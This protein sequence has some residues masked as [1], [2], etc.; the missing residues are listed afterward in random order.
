MVDGQDTE[1]RPIEHRRDPFYNKNCFRCGKKVH[2]SWHNERFEVNYV[3]NNE[4]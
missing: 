1:K 4:K 3:L 2:I